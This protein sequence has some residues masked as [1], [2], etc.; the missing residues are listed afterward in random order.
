MLKQY[1]TQ[2]RPYWTNVCQHTCHIYCDLSARKM[3]QPEQIQAMILEIHQRII[4]F[5][6]EK[7][8]KNQKDATK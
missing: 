6:C 2:S 4:L 5:K 1:S 8:Q 7:I 3:Q